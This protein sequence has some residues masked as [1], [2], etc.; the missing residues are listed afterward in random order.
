MI[1][2]M[3]QAAVVLD[4]HHTFVDKTKNYVWGDV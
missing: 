2:E 4:I 1:Y 3:V